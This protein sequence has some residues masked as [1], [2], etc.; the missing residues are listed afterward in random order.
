MESNNIQLANFG[1]LCFWCRE[2]VFKRLIRVER[3]V[4]G[5]MVGAKANPLYR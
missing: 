4:S 1:A 5:Y 3:A 2:V